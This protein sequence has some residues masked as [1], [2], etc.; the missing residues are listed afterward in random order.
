[1]G[2]RFFL[3]RSIIGCPPL[4]RFNGKEK[5]MRTKT[6]TMPQDAIVGMLKAL[7]ENALLEIFWKSFAQAEDAPLSKDER[8]DLAAADAEF[9]RGETVRWDDLR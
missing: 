9:E 6:I 4:H 7:P 1:L 8:S 3:D 2:G 5:E